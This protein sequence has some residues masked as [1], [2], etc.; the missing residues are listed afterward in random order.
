MHYFV[1]LTVD[2]MPPAVEMERALRDAFENGVDGRC[3]LLA[4]GQQTT[5][6]FCRSAIAC[7]ESVSGMIVAGS[8]AMQA[9]CS[10]LAGE[11]VATSYS[12]AIAPIL[13]QLLTGKAYCFDFNSGALDIATR[14]HVDLAIE[15][16]D[17][18]LPLPI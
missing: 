6:L 1:A 18:T 4:H 7:N 12:P 13:S 17:V 5:V 11:L 9:A 10:Q 2:V 8:D 16:P 3:Q 14:M 15:V